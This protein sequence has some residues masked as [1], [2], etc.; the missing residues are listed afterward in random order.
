LAPVI[1]QPFGRRPRFPFG[2]GPL[3]ELAIV[4]RVTARELLA[5]AGFAELV[6]RIS[7]GR[8][9]QAVARNG[10]VDPSR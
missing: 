4:F 9:E 5:L 10:A 3:E 8:V 6:E 7:A 2:F 1:G